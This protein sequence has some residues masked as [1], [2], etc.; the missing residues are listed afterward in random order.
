M[1][2]RMMSVIEIISSKSIGFLIALGLTYWIVPRIWGVEVAP[3]SAVF[4]TGLYTLAA[5]IR[6]YFFRRIFNWI[7]LR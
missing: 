2:S 3:E 4:V 1:Q 6:S 7:T 5:L